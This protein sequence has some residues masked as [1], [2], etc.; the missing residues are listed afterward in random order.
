MLS[1][2]ICSGDE[3]F[4]A[5]ADIRRV[6]D[7]FKVEVV[8]SAAIEADTAT[9]DAGLFAF[10]QLLIDEELAAMTAAMI[11]SKASHN[12]TLAEHLRD[13][14]LK[15]TYI[16]ACGGLFIWVAS[17]IF[18][19][20]VLTGFKLNSFVDD[21]M[22]PFFVG[23]FFVGIALSGIRWSIALT[24]FAAKSV[25]TRK[26]LLDGASLAVIFVFPVLLYFDAKA[27][28]LLFHAHTL[29]E[30]VVAL[31][32]ALASAFVILAWCYSESKG[33]SSG[34]FGLPI[35]I[36]G[37]I[38]C[39][40]GIMLVC[41]AAFLAAI[42]TI[43][44]QTLAPLVMTSRDVEEPLDGFNKAAKWLVLVGALMAAFMPTIRKALEQS[45]GDLALKV[46]LL[47]AGLKWSGFVA[48]GLLAI[49][50]IGLSSYAPLNRDSRARLDVLVE[51]K[52][53]K[54]S[55]NQRHLHHLAA[56]T[57]DDYRVFSRILVAEIAASQALASVQPPPGSAV[58]V[59]NSS[60]GSQS[61][62][63]ALITNIT[64]ALAPIHPESL[65]DRPVLEGVPEIDSARTEA[66]T[67]TL[68]TLLGKS[69]V[70]GDSIAGIAFG[71]V[72]DSVS[73]AAINR[74]VQTAYRSLATWSG[75]QKTKE[76]PL[77]T[78]LSTGDAMAV[79]DAIGR[80]MMAP[81]RLVYIKE[82]GRYA[83]TK[84]ESLNTDHLESMS[85]VSLAEVRANAGLA[86]VVPRWLMSAADVPTKYLGGRTSSRSDS[87]SSETKPFEEPKH[88]FVR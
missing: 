84:D 55:E 51:E 80:V 15:C 24:E 47:R 27:M 7:E 9:H 46:T 21:K 34:A 53:A 70:F 2:W 62:H 35:K 82:D 74:F 88:V 4:D 30:H 33:E 38:I 42:R 43:D 13:V 78:A 10:A 11:A 87:E 32:A 36:A 73:E 8:S 71:E 64:R 44:E 81:G 26:R 14:L 76:S 54:D 75:K 29:V 63:E 50:C 28:P 25:G 23:L 52:I 40:F 49:G 45:L 77:E 22:Q 41:D 20:S 56:A 58:I 68:S 19:V 61:A 60:P 17:C 69:V 31:T 83:F 65:P 86:G 5:L 59:I 3:K 37:H 79:T 57:R 16:Y 67:D 66:V 18:L 12:K 6:V 48:T 72:S 1:A 85:T 39:L